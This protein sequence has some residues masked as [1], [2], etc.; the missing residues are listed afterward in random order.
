MEAVRN[1]SNSF[2]KKKSMSTDGLRTR[3]LHMKTNY[4]TVFM[5]LVNIALILAI[6]H[7]RDFIRHFGY[8][9]CDTVADTEK[10]KAAKIHPIF[11][12]FSAFYIRN[13]FI[14]GFDSAGKPLASTPGAE[15]EILERK[16]TS[17]FHT[18][19]KIT[20]KVVKALNFGSYN[21]LG[22]LQRDN[23]NLICVVWIVFSGSC[24]N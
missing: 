24:L 20:G 18:D 21:Y 23:C 15:I 12:G 5:V 1:V 13:I 2:V 14:Y 3:Q 6:G 9:K 8:L 17:Q 16:R 10:N 7:F 4:F 22:E 19:F 11:T